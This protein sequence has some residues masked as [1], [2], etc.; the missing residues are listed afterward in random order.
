MNVLKGVVVQPAGVTVT[1]GVLV[2]CAEGDGEPQPLTA[3]ARSDPL[4]RRQRFMIP[5]V[6]IMR[7]QA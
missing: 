4:R 2:V 6:Q 3:N 7:V 5:P 1:T